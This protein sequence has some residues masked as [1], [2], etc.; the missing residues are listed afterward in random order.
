MIFGVFSLRRVARSEKRDFH[1]NLTFLVVFF[2]ILRVRGDENPLFFGLWGD[3]F[4]VRKPTRFFHRF[5]RPK[6]RK[7]RSFWLHFGPKI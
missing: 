6:V 2:M 5:L 3:F 1:E 4:D 7:V